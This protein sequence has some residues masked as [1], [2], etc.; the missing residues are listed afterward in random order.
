MDKIDKAL[1]RLT[2]K[3]KQS[4]KEIVKTLRSWS[5]NN[6]D[7]KKL[8]IGND[9]FRVKRG[10]IRIIYQVRNNQIFILK[11]GFRKESTYKLK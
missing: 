7:I 10:R 11:I 6:L 5:F 1:S 2:P 8:K 4:V 9:I 3:E